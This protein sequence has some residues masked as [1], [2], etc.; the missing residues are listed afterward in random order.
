MLSA[1]F[2]VAA[3]A[4]WQSRGKAQYGPGKVVGQPYCDFIDDNTCV[5][6]DLVDS[7]DDK[8]RTIHHK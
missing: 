8:G 7:V 2:P 3:L 5:A 1:V 4:E 6:V